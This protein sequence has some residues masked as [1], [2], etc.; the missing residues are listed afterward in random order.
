MVTNKDWDFIAKI[1]DTDLYGLLNI[2]LKE[3]GEEDNVTD[4]LDNIKSAFNEF[5]Q[6][7]NDDA[8]T[9]LT[10]FN[11][12]G[13]MLEL[14]GTE[15]HFADFQAERKERNDALFPRCMSLIDIISLALEHGL[16]IKK[17]TLN[18]KKEK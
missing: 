17:V 12:E 14:E 11:G 7:E 9:T 6:E 16:S 1:N 8:Y 10:F 13:H 18:N 5:F 4:T 3:L 15:K 2:M